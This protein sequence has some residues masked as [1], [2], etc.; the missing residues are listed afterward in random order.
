MKILHISTHL[1]GGV[2][3]VLLNWQNADK[4]NKHSF[5]CLGYN[6]DNIIDVCKDKGIE[7][8]SHA[9]HEFICDY[10]RNNDVD[11]V[12][13]HYWNHPLLIDFM[14]K[15][16]LP[17]CRLVIYSHIAGRFIPYVIPTKIIDYADKFIHSS[18]SAKGADESNSIMST[19]GLEKCSNISLK[20]HNGFNVLYVGTLDF[21]KLRDDF[22]EICLEIVREIPSV[23]FT[24]CGTGSSQEIIIKQ[25]KDLNI[26]DKFNFTGLV[27]DLTP[28]L[29]K[30]D[31]FLY[32]LN[33]NHYGTGEQVL[34]EA[35]S[36]GVIP[37]VFDNPCE[38]LIVKNLENGFVV[39]DVKG[40][41]NAIK[42]LE[43]ASGLKDSLSIGAKASALE[44]YSEEKFTNKWN[45]VFKEIMFLEK[46][47]RKWNSDFKYESGIVAF[48][49]SLG[50]ES[51]IFEEYIT[52]EKLI[53]QKLSSPQWR[54]DSKGSIRQ[55]LHH[56]PHDIYLNK[57]QNILN[58][59]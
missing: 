35:M 20:E 23:M 56:F 54:S 59:D 25:A 33:R 11:I 13:I 43:N 12:I 48:L 14:V 30:A 50:C 46:K 28:Y 4:G 9:D 21:A 31:A 2:G 16:K 34:G 1:G 51:E 38:M 5:I 52:I 49:E 44:M 8:H 3:S 17:K 18:V 26:I 6:F 27:D 58:E 41:V 53:K 7:L 55:Y 36:C 29:E 10:I 19:S 57:I 39:N 40:C 15:S 47:E 42:S 37:I 32:P 24:I 45:A 22:I